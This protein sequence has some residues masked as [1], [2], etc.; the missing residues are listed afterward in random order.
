ME[1]LFS[2][3]DRTLSDRLRSDALGRVSVPPRG[4]T[5]PVSAR[6]RSV[7]RPSRNHHSNE[8][9]DGE[10][11]GPFSRTNQSFSS[12]RSLAFYPSSK[13]RNSLGEQA[14]YRSLWVRPSS[15]RKVYR[16]SHRFV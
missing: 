8:T 13:P 10:L 4:V 6:P 16:I 11:E 9:K 14:K 2:A 3:L 7:C 1:C 15:R 5:C 12:P